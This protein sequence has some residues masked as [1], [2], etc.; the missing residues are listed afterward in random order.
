MAISSTADVERNLECLM[1]LRLHFFISDKK[2]VSKMIDFD[3]SKCFFL[4][5]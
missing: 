3:K 4:I 5:G 2:I 1:Q